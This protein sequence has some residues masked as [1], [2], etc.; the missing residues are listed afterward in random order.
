MLKSGV[1][2]VAFDTDEFLSVEY[3]FEGTKPGKRQETTA[4]FQ[5][6]SISIT[7]QP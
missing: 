7:I 6:Q 4:S 5:V 2:V 1:S 3:G